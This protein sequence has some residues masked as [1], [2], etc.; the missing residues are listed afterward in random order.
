MLME[1]LQVNKKQIRT[2][3]LK[4]RFLKKWIKDK[5]VLS[6]EE[7]YKKAF[8]KKEFRNHNRIYMKKEAILLMTEKAEI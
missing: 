6:E 1:D 8:K 5:K 4:L 7:I 3:L 2:L